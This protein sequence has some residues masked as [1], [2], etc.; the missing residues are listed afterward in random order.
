VL[1]LRFLRPARLSSPLGELDGLRPTDVLFHGLDWAGILA[2]APRVD[3]VGPA[4]RRAVPLPPRR[5]RVISEGAFRRGEVG[6]YVRR[7]DLLWEGSGRTTA[8]EVELVQRDG[9]G[10]SEVRYYFDMHDFLARWARAGVLADAP[11]GWFRAPPAATVDVVASGPESA[12]LTLSCPATGTRLHRPAASAPVPSAIARAAVGEEPCT[13]GFG[14]G[15]TGRLT[16]L[17]AGGSL[18]DRAGVADM[19]LPPL[20]WPSGSTA[21]ALDLA[22]R[23]TSDAGA[24]RGEVHL[25]A[26]RSAPP[27]N[28][29][30]TARLNMPVEGGIRLLLHRGNVPGIAGA[31]RDPAT[32][33]IGGVASDAVSVRNEGRD[34]YFT[35]ARGHPSWAVGD[36]DLLVTN[37][38]GTSGTLRAG[39]RVTAAIAPGLAGLGA[40]LRVG[41][42][43]LAALERFP[44]GEELYARIDALVL[45]YGRAL[46]R[47]ARRIGDSAADRNALAQH[48][49]DRVEMV[50][51]ALQ[52]LA[53]VAD[54]PP[55][56]RRESVS[57]HNPSHDL[58]QFDPH[59][60]V[61]FTTAWETILAVGGRA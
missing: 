36:D 29:A 42:L 55:F 4:F 20:T 40:S 30:R 3:G 24:P 60:R 9:A 12:V 26:L 57:I 31:F 23:G 1:R 7:G 39:V 52:Q 51:R 16:A 17:L 27:G 2:H 48:L 21:D 35:P 61:L 13:V 43:E 10:A 33:S 14:D 22:V 49:R 15:S 38:D 56:A 32:V 19:R 28:D 53:E 59:G 25:N 34:L 11:T 41:L 54:Q 46:D 6:A 47:L 58:Q 45:P 18:G 5:E 50:F 8:V 44:A 37:G